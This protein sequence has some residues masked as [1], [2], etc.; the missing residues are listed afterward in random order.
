M[1]NKPWADE[2]AD[3]KS[4]LLGEFCLSFLA[5]IFC[6]YF[7]GGWAL[8]KIMRKEYAIGICCI[9]GLLFA[10]DLLPTEVKQKINPRRL[11]RVLAQRIHIR[12]FTKLGKHLWL[13]FIEIIHNPR[14]SHKRR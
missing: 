1:G 12:D 10:L 6:S 3:S 7:G 5:G 2:K 9:G 8:E 11:C 14:I 4:S 13:V